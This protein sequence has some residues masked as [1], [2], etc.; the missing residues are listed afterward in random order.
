M[1]CEWFGFK[2][3]WTVFSGLASKL[4]ARVFWFRPQNRQLRFGDFVFKITATV[5]W[6]GP[7]NHA[8]FSLLVAPQNRWREDGVGHTSR[9]A[10]LLRPKASHARVSQSGLKTGGGTT[11]G[12]ARGTIMEVASGSS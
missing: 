2:T 10:S 11:V 12:G 1:V 4:M 6:F 3:T 9:S 7:Q 8:G 5:S